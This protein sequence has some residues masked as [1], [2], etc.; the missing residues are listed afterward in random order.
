[1]ELNAVVD[2]SQME[3]SNWILLESWNPMVLCNLELSGRLY[4]SVGCRRKKMIVEEG[5][6]HVERGNSSK[7][8]R[9]YRRVYIPYQRYES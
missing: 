4:F 7:V 5:L 6:C 9:M 2:Y 1:M 8:Q 3:Y